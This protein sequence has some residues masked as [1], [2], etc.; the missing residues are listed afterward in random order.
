MISRIAG[1]SLICLAVAVAG[2]PAAAAFDPV[3]ADDVRYAEFMNNPRDTTFPLITA[4]KSS[5]IFQYINSVDL[6]IYCVT[7]D[8]RHDYRFTVLLDSEYSESLKET[9]KFSFAF[10]PVLDKY[11]RHDNYNAL[12]DSESDLSENLELDYHEPLKVEVVRY[13]R[14]TYLAKYPSLYGKAFLET[15]IL[16]RLET[17]FQIT[18]VLRSEEDNKWVV[19]AQVPVKTDPAVLKN[20]SAACAPEE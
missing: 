9:G 4:T 1:F 15:S 17:P 3:P 7:V 5:D 18:L 14:P 11:K 19:L 16:K 8:N 10:G 12:F 20:F 2:L 6:H 13:Y